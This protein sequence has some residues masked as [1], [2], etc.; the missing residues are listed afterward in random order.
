MATDLSKYFDV[1]RRFVARWR[2]EKVAHIRDSALGW[3]LSLAL[4][5]ILGICLLLLGC[6]LCDRRLW[7]C[8]SPANVADLRSSGK[9]HRR[10]D[11]RVVGE[12][13]VRHRE[14]AGRPRGAGLRPSRQQYARHQP[15]NQDSPIDLAV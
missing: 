1:L 3:V 10:T 8:R 13:P 11:V 4:F 14:Q 9:H 12:L 7:R 15:G 5:F 6:E 2:A